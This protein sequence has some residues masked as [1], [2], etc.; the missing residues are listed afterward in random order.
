M[1]I[2]IFVG[3]AP[4]LALLLIVRTVRR[5]RDETEHFWPTL[6]AGALAL[7]LWVAASWLM[8][9][10]TFGTLWDVA[11]LQPR[12]AGHFPEGWPI[13]GCLAIYLAVGA[14]LFVA[15]GHANSKELPA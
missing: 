8:A 9:L 1:F 15:L 11:H 2:L 4:A 7:G 14:G 6:L 3:F 13:Y 10:L 12:P 5:V